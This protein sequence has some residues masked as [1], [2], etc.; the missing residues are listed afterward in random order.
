MHEN[1]S[2]EQHV[3]GSSDRTFGFVFVAAFA[4]IALW[5]LFSAGSPRWWAAVVAVGFGLVAVAR[6]ALLANLNRLWMKLGLLLGRVVSPI[7]LGVLFYGVFTPL[8]SLMRA[9][10]KDPLHLARDRAAATYWRTRE[11]PGPPPNSM[12]RQF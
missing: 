5:P 11:P 4:V 9:T 12:E 10:G 2:R 3:K 8:G 6:P 7:A 1:L